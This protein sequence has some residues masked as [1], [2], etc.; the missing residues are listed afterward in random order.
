[1]NSGRYQTGA[2]AGRGG[3]GRGRDRSDLV[4]AGKLVHGNEPWLNAAVENSVQAQHRR[5]ARIAKASDRLRNDV[6]IALAL[7][8]HRAI[9]KPPEAGLIGWV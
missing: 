6:L 5:G 9:Y 7:A 1:M 3:V 4:N 2:G 8:T